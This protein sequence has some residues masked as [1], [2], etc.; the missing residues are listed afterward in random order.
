MDRDKREHPRVERR[1]DVFAETL[2]TRIWQ[3]IP[4]SDNPYVATEVRCHGYSLDELASR[5]SYPEVLY[6]LMRGELPTVDEAQ[7][8]QH[9][10]I[11][12]I[13]PGPR[14]PATRSAMAAGVGKTDRELIIPI[15]LGT[16][17][18]TQT[19]AG[20]VEPAMRFLRQHRRK[21][22]ADVAR[23]C[24]ENW[25]CLQDENLAPGFGCVYG[26]IDPLTQRHANTLQRLPASGEIIDWAQHFSDA[27]HEYGAGWLRTGLA[28]AA[29]C[30]LGFQPRF[31]GG[32]YQLLCTP[33]LLAH[34]V[35]YANKP[36]SAFPFIPDDRYVIEEPE[37]ENSG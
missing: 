27:L 23:D 17:S 14:H 3:E 34:G 4:T 19:G 18:G 31:G 24:A 30:D 36:V 15:A 35:E 13:N 32:M 6:L 16:L 20:E 9:L 10:M 22:P 28:A 5:K 25:S 12:L 29:L 1:D 33:G 8:L 26:S 37:P 2:E 21:D 7:L 11:L